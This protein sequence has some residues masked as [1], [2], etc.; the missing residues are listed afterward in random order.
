MKNEHLSVD[1]DRPILERAICEIR[2]EPTLSFHARNI[3]RICEPFVADMPHW[4]ISLA[5]LNLADHSDRRKAHIQL[6]VRNASF[7]FRN[8]FPGLYDNFRA[9]AGKYARKWL[10]E[11]QILNLTRVGVRVYYVVPVERSFEDVRNI[12]FKAFCKENLISHLNVQLSDLTVAFVF[13]SDTEQCNYTVSVLKPDEFPGG[14]PPP[15]G[16]VLPKKTSLFV[17][18]DRYVKDQDF[19][20]LSRILDDAKKSVEKTLYSTI[21]FMKR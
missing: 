20:R 5:E 17:D 1:F 3:G 14:E 21:E 4:G 15:D 9:K 16:E 2:Y 12:F 8:R 19:R 7:W 11:L 10:Q 13:S 18:I 6:I